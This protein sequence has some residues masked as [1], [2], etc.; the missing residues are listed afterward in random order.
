MK[1]PAS[2][3]AGRPPRQSLRIA[4]GAIAFMLLLGGCAASP[5]T[6]A[7]SLEPGPD[8][9]VWPAPPQVPRYALARILIGER[10]FIAPEQGGG[11]TVRSAL[12]WIAGLVIGEPEYIELRR[13]VSGVTD[14]RGWIYVVDASYQA[15]VVFDMTGHRLLLW[16]WVGPS[17][18][19]VSPVAITGDGTGGFLVTDSELGEVIR[20]GAD[21]QPVG[22]FGKGILSRP[23]GIARDG[24]AGRIYVA[25]TK[26]H[27]IKIFDDRGVLID[28]LGIR[29]TEPGRFNAPTHL[30]FKD[31]ALYVADTLNFRIQVFD[32]SGDGRLTFGGIGLFVGNMTRPKGVAVGGD[33]RIYVV[34]SFYDHLLVFDSGG[35]LLL[36]I[37][38]TGAGVGQFYLPSGVWTDD[39]GHVYVADMYNGRVVVFKELT[40]VDGT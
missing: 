25:D 39:V 27:D 29:G 10:D 16:Q 14:G 33:G 31:G 40:P 36:P 18:R 30:L 26:S 3:A 22:R 13:P 21:G 24:Q 23:T 5:Q 28:T 11:D 1:L 15:V 2:C 19:F 4:A 20:L 38:G 8:S 6:M 9:P 35:H 34:E 7:I 37:G 12:Y 17:Q 32:R